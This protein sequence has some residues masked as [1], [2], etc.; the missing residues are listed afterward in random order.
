MIGVKNRY[1]R[2]SQPFHIIQHEENPISVTTGVNMA[3][4]GWR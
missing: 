1:L 2:I 3:A 4:L